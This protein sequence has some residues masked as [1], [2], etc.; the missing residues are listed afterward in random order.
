[1]QGEASDWNKGLAT[2]PVVLLALLIIAQGGFYTLPTCL[3]GIAAVVAS[4][5]LAVARRGRIPG[6]EAVPLL[7]FLVAGAYLLSAVANGMTLTELKE[8][9]KWFAVA[10]FANC[11]SLQAR[12][13]RERT[14]RILTWALLLFSVFGILVFCGLFA[15]PGYMHDGRL[16]FFLQYANS[17][18]LL[19]AIAVFLCLLGGKLQTRLAFLPFAAMLMTKSAGAAAVVLLVALSC[20][21][22]LLRKKQY[23]ML[24]LAL[25]Q[26]ATGLA[27]FLVT[28]VA[29]GDAGLASAVLAMAAW[30]F[31]SRHEA[32]TIERRARV[33]AIVTLALFALLLVVVV[34]LNGERLVEAC[35]TFG[36]R[37]NQMQTALA[38]IAESPLFGVGPDNWQYLYP[39]V[40]ESPFHTRVVHCGYL[41]IAAD[42]GLLALSLFVA[43]VVLGV[44]KQLR[45]QDFQALLV[46]GL[47]ALHALV[48]FD[49]RFGSLA[50]LLALALVSPLG[51]QDKLAPCS[52]GAF[53]T[54]LTTTL[55]CFPLCIAAIWADASMTI[56]EQRVERGDGQGAAI[57]CMKTPLASQDVHAQ[58]LYLQALLQEGEYN[59]VISFAEHNIPASDRQALH[60][61]SAYLETGDLVS[62]KM[63]LEEEQ[64]RQPH[65]KSLKRAADALMGE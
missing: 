26:C 9:G 56:I 19:F 54:K 11:C 14:W 55:L 46:A 39:Y 20:T 17:A 40:Q 10:A 30:G 43:A 2:F 59:G 15:S 65:N 18:A 12:H 5:C 7:F 22:V 8:A 3:A 48:D 60:I 37:L 47:I 29:G 36:T 58:E 51:D 62:A 1:M 21:L 42:A 16:Q 34:L 4:V 57:A 50:F 33:T 64:E 31:L 6:V 28:L 52:R 45:A 32:C 49:L 27:V 63:V 61:A 44:R 24:L 13:E 53:P 23:G 25:E 41:Q 38:L 35:S